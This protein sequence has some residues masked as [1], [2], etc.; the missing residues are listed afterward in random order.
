MKL[1][2]DDRVESTQTYVNVPKWSTLEGRI[3]GRVLA[4]NRITIRGYTQS[5]FDPPTFNTM[6]PTNLYYT[7]RNFVEGRLEGGRDELTYYLV[8]NFQ[9]YRDASR[10]T[11]VQS[12]QYTAGAIWQM[13]NSLNVFGEYHHE[14]WSGH[15]G[16]IS[17]YPNIG[18]YMPTTNTGIV[19]II[20]NANK[21]MYISV[22]YTGFGTRN[23]NPLL[24]QDG[25]TA[26]SFV[27]INGHYRFPKG[28]ELGFTVAPW[29]YHDNV[30]SSLNY[31]A[32][33]LMITGSA[34]Y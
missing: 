27:T 23:N 22:T 17:G 6:D 20:Y 13:A 30:V 33:V 15:S 24:L 21:R 29:T 5:L 11:D 12:S 10:D 28:Y 25:N 19:Q 3:S 7:S 9:D 1:Q 16:S 34:R 2:D 18:D 26:G 31:S 14:G 4:D 32:T 8:Y